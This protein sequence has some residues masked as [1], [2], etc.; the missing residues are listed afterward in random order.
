M[1][2][3]NEQN[4]LATG[5]KGDETRGITKLGKKA[6]QKIVDKKMILDVSHL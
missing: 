2:T 6:V 3:W 1:L 4:A 5:A